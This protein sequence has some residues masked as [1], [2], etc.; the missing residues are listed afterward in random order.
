MSTRRHS[1]S[2]SFYSQKLIHLS[3]FYCSTHPHTHTLEEHC[4][5][6]EDTNIHPLFILYVLRSLICLCFNFS[7]LISLNFDIHNYSDAWDRYE[8]IQH[9]VH[10]FDLSGVPFSNSGTVTGL[11]LIFIKEKHFCPEWRTRRKNGQVLVRTYTYT[12]IFGLCN[13]RSYEFY[14]IDQSLPPKFHLTIVH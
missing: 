10:D 6:L 13:I 2:L 12:I 4:R 1:L 3:E 14:F 7:C 9:V 5:V 8:R 11:P